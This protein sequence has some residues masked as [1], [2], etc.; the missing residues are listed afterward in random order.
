MSKISEYLNYYRTEMGERKFRKL[1]KEVDTAK[2][3]NQFIRDSIEQM[4]LPGTNDFYA[5]IMHSLKYSF[6]GREKI[7]AVA[8]LLLNRWND[9][10]NRKYEIADSYELE[11]FAS[12][13]IRE[14]G[15]LGV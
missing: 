14:G 7:V 11:K 15:Q 8:L 10:V 2:R 5:C 1:I 6:A 4:I 13:L 3:F 9:E 12:I